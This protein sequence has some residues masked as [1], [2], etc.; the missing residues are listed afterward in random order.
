MSIRKR[1]ASSRESR[2]ET[3]P[4]PPKP[5]LDY[6]RKQAKALLRRLRAGD[7]DALARACARHGAL[8]HATVADITLADAQLVIAREYGFASWPLLFQYFRDV[9]RQTSMRRPGSRHDR[10][11][12]EGSARSLIVQHRNRQPNAGRA[13]AASVPRL[14]GLTIDEVFTSPVS[15]DDARLAVARQNG[16]ASWEM[17]MQAIAS[18]QARYGDP[19]L[20]FVATLGLTRQAINAGDLEGLKSVVAEHP[21]LLRPPVE[22]RRDL[23]TLIHVALGAE[24]RAVPGARAI[25]DWLATQSVDVPLALN[26]RFFGKPP[27]TTANVR[28]LL[29][30]GADP[31]WIAPNGVS[32]LEHALLRYWNGAAVDLI[33]RHATPKRALWIAAGLGRVEEVTRFL[34]ATGKPTAA[35][36][37]DRPDFVAAGWPMLSASAPDDTEILA[38]A[39]FVAMLNDRVVV[40]E[41]LI[42]R[43]FPID[44]LGWEMPLVSFAAGNQRVRV[45]ECLVRRGANLDLR[46]RHPDMSARELA[47]SSFE[48]RPND[49]TAR[50]ILELCGAGEPDRVIA[51]RDARP[52]P[53]PEF[54]GAVQ[55]ALELAADDAVRRAESEVRF[56]NLVIG[57]MRASPDAMGMLRLAGVDMECLRANF[58]TRILLPTD[59]VARVKLSLDDAAQ[60][61][62]SRAIDLARQRKS[63]TVALPQMLSALIDADDGFLRGLLQS[64]GS[65]VMKLRDRIDSVLRSAD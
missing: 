23:T 34:D 4:L 13:F 42:D 1:G 55:E 57:V 41:Y 51:E 19:W 48:Q 24:E 43:G 45:V 33:A 6:E 28:F 15:E 60:T 32:V 14:Y 16:C 17:L 26:E 22:D 58:G 44:Y 10:E 27:L 5:S 12:Y 63:D 7:H 31:D 64:C 59:R 39:F 20:T 62:V 40:L 50:R 11:F 25:T 21:E 9:E 38:E 47:R 35:A 2:P 18:E 56:D 61:T 52:A 49:P 54:A 29:D 53:E 37:R 30:R 46:G 65:S 8:P 36:Y 3:R